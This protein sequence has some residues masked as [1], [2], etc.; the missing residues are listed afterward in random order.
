ML[1]LGAGRHQ[2]SCWEQ[3]GM[4]TPTIRVGSRKAASDRTRDSDFG[5]FPQDVEQMRKRIFFIS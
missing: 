5:I 1:E 4:R 3:E 2:R